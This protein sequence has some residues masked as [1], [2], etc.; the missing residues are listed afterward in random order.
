MFALRF[1]FDSMCRADS[2]ASLPVVRLEVAAANQINDINNFFP[3]LCGSSWVLPVLCFQEFRSSRA[4]ASCLRHA[5][6]VHLHMLFLVLKTENVLG[7]RAQVVWCACVL[8]PHCRHTPGPALVPVGAMWL[9]SRRWSS[10]CAWGSPA[11][12]RGLQR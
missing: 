6:G 5:I 11:A 1:S 4:T 2:V 12:S 9:G 3:S 10:L 8:L 7:L